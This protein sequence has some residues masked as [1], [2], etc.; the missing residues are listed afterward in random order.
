MWRG[1]VSAQERIGFQ[2]EE[3]ELMRILLSEEIIL[4]PERL[5][6]WG[7][8]VVVHGGS[9]YNQIRCGKI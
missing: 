2:T 3:S 6:Q 1:V 4:V 7:R 5:V 8:G 9:G